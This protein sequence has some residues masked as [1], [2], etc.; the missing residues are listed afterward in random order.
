MTPD[1]EFR[2]RFVDRY[3]AGESAAALSKDAG[4]SAQAIVRWV[5]KCGGQ[6]RTVGEAV[7]L[8]RGTVEQCF[9]SKYI[10]LPNKCWQWT[11]GVN[12]HGYA[13]FN[14]RNGE[15]HAYRYSYKRFKGPIGH[16]LEI[17]H[18]CRNRKCV[19]P[20]HL[21]A[22]THAENIAR[23]GNFSR[24][25]THCKRGH[26]FSKE[27]TYQRGHTRH[28]KTCKIERQRQARAAA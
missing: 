18:L 28:C 7:R 4:F 19:N 11:A 10:V 9:D 21:E 2:K 23:G 14:D 1:Y 26:E 6:V 25:K 5:Q 20:D 13:S 22:V 12:N 17:D 24:A 16:G 27:N 3:L 8:A 15:T